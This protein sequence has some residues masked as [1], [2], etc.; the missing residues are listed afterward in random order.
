MTGRRLLSPV[1]ALVA[2]LGLTACGGDDQPD[3]AAQPS[4]AEVEVAPVEDVTVAQLTLP[5]DPDWLAVD[6]HGVWVQRNSGELAVVD[7]ATN[8]VSRS[9]Q[10]GA[11]E[12]CGGIGASYGAVWTCVT[13]D[14]LRLDPVTLEVV[15]R[16]AVGKQAVQGHLVG[17]FD[18]VWVLTSDG[19][20][21][22]GID[23][24]TNEV[25]TEFELPARCTDVTLGDDAL[26]LPCK[27][28]DRVLK[29]D[30]TTG[31]VLL[32]LALDNPV[33]VAVDGDVWLGTATTTLQ[34][35]PDS[36]EVLLEG[37]AGSAP[38]GGV[39]LD[40]DSVWVRNGTDFLIRLDRATGERR[41]QI[42]A[43]ELTSGG[44]LLV[45]DGDVWTTAFD[46][47]VLFR[48]DPGAG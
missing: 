16:L 1:V 42:T 39:A 13:S 27:V 12:L 4:Q 8:E 45:I 20:T 38:D 31:E 47:Q 40:A 33:S 18:R 21:L 46:D 15:A 19:S 14:V 2:A 37:D 36:G 44:D 3:A 10:L 30:P 22:V 6:E 25:A 11:T 9:V 32:D 17:G 41:Q 29:V 7:P 24:A 26:W 34:L 43:E 48:V 23:P 35:D 5:G 28:D